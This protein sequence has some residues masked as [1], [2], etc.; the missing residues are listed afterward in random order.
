MATLLAIQVLVAAG[1]RIGM[2]V[3]IIVR[4]IPLLHPM[5][6]PI[7]STFIAAAPT[8]ARATFLMM[9]VRTAPAPEAPF[10]RLLPIP[11]VPLMGLPL[12]TGTPLRQVV[13]QG[14]RQGLCQVLRQTPRKVLLQAPCPVPCLDQC[15]GP[16]PRCHLQCQGPR[17]R[18]CRPGQDR[19]HH[20]H[21][22][23]LPHK[24]LRLPTITTT[25]TTTLLKYHPRPRIWLMGMPS[26]E[27]LVAAKENIPG[28]MVR[29]TDQGMVLNMEVLGMVPVKSQHHRQGGRY[30]LQ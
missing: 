7:L 13:C 26:R 15:L 20:H 4:G 19:R 17:D 16:F 1:I 5:P 10:T 30:Q 3:G 11:D 6:T 22:A 29:S 18:L 12:L 25:L 27:T 9:K 23:L 2:R 24:R 14:P 8:R 21:K 28:D